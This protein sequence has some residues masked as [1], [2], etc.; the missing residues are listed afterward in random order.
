MSFEDPALAAWFAHR[1]LR[2]PDG[3]AERLHHLRAIKSAR[4]LSVGV[5]LPALNEAETI[6]AIC[7]CITADLIE[8]GLVDQLV[9]IDSGST[10]RTA[11]AAR[12]TGAEVYR[13][14]ELLPG[15]GPSGDL[16]KGESLWK[17]LAVVTT[18]IIVWLDA[19]TRNFGPHFVTSLLSPLLEDDGVVFAKAFY[20]RPLDAGNEL[21]AM[22]GARVTEIGIRPLINLFFPELAGFIQPLSG[23]YAGLRDVLL[24]IP[25]GTGYDVDVLLLLDV[26]SAH[27]LNAVAQVD[28]GSRIHRNRDVPALGK[29]SFEIARSLFRRLEAHDRVKFAEDLPFQLVQFTERD[30]TYDVI[31]YDAHNNARPPMR[32]IL[33]R[34]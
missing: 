8:T 21:L 32:S 31:P 20:E 26:V 15:A 17:S 13:A 10:D 5:C 4:G 27:G 23:E 18:D 29:M 11:A 28:L 9:V 22:G 24:D 3:G 16:G 1:T 6:A 25:F 34:S 12:A 14:D 2:P 7:A 30:G 19:D 33:A